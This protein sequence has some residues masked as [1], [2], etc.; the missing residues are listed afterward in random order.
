MGPTCIGTTVHYGRFAGIWP[1]GA[2]VT[3]VCTACQ[4]AWGADG[5]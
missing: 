5:G 3:A 1:G 2:V 4:H